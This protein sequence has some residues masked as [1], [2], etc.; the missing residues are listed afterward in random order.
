[1]LIEDIDSDD[2]C[3]SEVP[4]ESAEDVLDS[5][6][7][8]HGSAVVRQGGRSDEELARNFWNEIGYPTPASRFWEVASP[9]TE[10][11]PD[12]ELRF[13]RSGAGS[14]S[15]AAER[16]DVDVGV[17]QVSAV[18]KQAT[19]SHVFTVLRKPR[20]SAWRGPVPPH[21][22]SPPV[23]LGQFFPAVMESSLPI[24][25]STSRPLAETEERFRASLL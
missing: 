12:D 10:G 14:S 13:C 22:V 4:F 9:S 15:A 5:P 21:R 20:A 16:K 25:P 7:S 6:T 2:S 3:D 17:Q 11:M 19:A 1:V 23:V 8:R 18:A 24:T